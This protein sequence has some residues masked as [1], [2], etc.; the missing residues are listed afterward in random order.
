M[1]PNYASPLKFA[2]YYASSFFRPSLWSKNG[3]LPSPKRIKVCDCAIDTWYEH[4]KVNRLSYGVVL[5]IVLRLQAIPLV[6]LPTAYI[7]TDAGARDSARGSSH[8][9]CLWK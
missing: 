8:Q 1:R 2:R 5:K 3:N 9:L 7:W 4:M 6:D